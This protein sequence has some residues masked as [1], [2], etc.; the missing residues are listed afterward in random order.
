MPKVLTAAAV[1][2]YRAGHKRREVRDGA[3]PGLH[4][5]IQPSGAKSYALRFRRPNGKSA[6]LTLG[7]VDLSGKEPEG[8]PMLGTPLTLASARS[9][10][11]KAHRDRA[12][13][14]DVAARYVDEKRRRTTE[15]ANRA[16]NTFAALTHRFIDEH[17]RPKTRRWR[18]TA[19]LLGW[20][21]PGEGSD[22]TIVEGGLSHRWRDKPIADIDGHDIHAV[23]DEAR[24]D[25]VPGVKRRNDGS[26]DARG[27]AMARCL[28][29][30]FAWLVQHRRITANPCLGVYCPPAPA[31]RDRVLSDSEIRWFWRACDQ[32]SEPFGQLLRLLLLTGGRREE[33]ARMTR[34]ELSEDGTVW[35]LPKERAKNRRAHVVPLPPL[36]RYIIAGVKVVESK[37]GYIFS[38]TGTTPVSGFS[39]IKRKLDDE[40]LAAARR[41]KEQAHRDP[42][43]VIITKWRFHD[44]RRT[45]ATGMAEIGI[46]P[47]IVEAALN[48]VSG[49]KAAVAGTYNRAAYAAEKKAALE[50]WA[51]HVEG[52]MSGRPAKV[53]ALR[54]KG[55]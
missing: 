55:T 14:R 25:G 24:R 26:S 47:H 22:P 1:L 8:E 36:A 42:S 11:A 38:T 15:D 35:N 4:L 30:L 50:R 41:E 6:K 46:S 45:A 52:L 53:V 27:R 9:L 20:S 54:N 10:A 49:A 3:T 19:R 43:E 23:V 5:V 34:A 51:S 37:P 2:K 48:H 40:M 7:P 29:K 18:D 33:V 31:A 44:L 12:I 21:Y 39:K 32:I 13:G 17:A 16:K 28:S